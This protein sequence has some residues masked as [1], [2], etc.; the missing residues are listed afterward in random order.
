MNIYKLDNNLFDARLDIDSMGITNF[1]SSWIYKDDKITFLVDPGPAVLLPSLEEALSYLKVNKDGLDYIL[2]THIHIDHA[3]SIGNL[4]EFFPRAKVVCHPSAIKH[5]INP[6]KLWK[7]SVETLGDLALQYGKIFSVSETSF[8]LPENLAKAGIVP[9]ETLGHAPHHHSYLFKNYLFAGE[10]AGIIK[11]VNNRLYMRP[12]TPPIF[13]YK[14]WKHSIETLISMSLKKYYICY[15]HYG[16]RQ[17]AHKMLKLAYN[18]LRTWREII[19]K[20]SITTDFEDLMKKIF[21]ILN[22]KD[23]FF[24]NFYQMDRS[25]QDFEMKLLSNA[26]KGILKDIQ[27]NK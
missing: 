8:A 20:L 18:Q 15:A 13:N 22:K 14:A 24:A 26:I 6:E 23:K 25:S 21:T 1:L 4:L 2:L 5:L 19:S 27:A 11:S 17:N 3:G 16:Y 9:I 12:A 7:A 10:V